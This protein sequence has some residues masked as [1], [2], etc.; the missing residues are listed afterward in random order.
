MCTKILNSLILTIC[1][2]GTCFSQKNN[3]K[4]YP[5]LEIK[6]LHEWEQLISETSIKSSAVNMETKEVETAILKTSRN[7]FILH[8][9]IARVECNVLLFEGSEK[10][11]KEFKDYSL[12]YDKEGYL[13]EVDEGITCISYYYNEKGVV[14]ST[15][16]RIS[17]MGG[18]GGG[19][20]FLAAK[21]I[22]MDSI[23]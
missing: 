11:K 20:S 21:E 17:V 3:W 6:I 7:T 22:K 23:G 4:S 5:N 13:T 10:P 12:S 18:K 9:K 8:Y 15:A 16:I 14:D 1:I 2:L 19:I